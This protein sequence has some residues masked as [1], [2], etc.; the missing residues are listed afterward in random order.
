VCNSGVKIVV[1]AT[2][3]M[4]KVWME[5]LANWQGNHGFIGSNSI[6][7]TIQINEVDGK[8]GVKPMELLLC[9]VMNF[10]IRI[11]NL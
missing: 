2:A 6:G 5:V 11:S 4:E 1:E 10:Q 3:L 9:G 7:G 8:P